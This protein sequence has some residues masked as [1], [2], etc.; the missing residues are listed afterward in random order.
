ML[1]LFSSK[2]LSILFLAGSLALGLW[3][4]TGQQSQAAGTTYHVATSGNDN[5][6]GTQSSPFRTLQKAVSAVRPGDTVIVHAGRYAGFGRRNFQGASGSPI[7]IKAAPGEHVILDGYITPK[8]GSGGYVI[9]LGGVAAHLI[10]DGFEITNSDPLIDQ[11]RQLPI[12][13][14]SDCDA[15]YPRRAKITGPYYGIRLESDPATSH[16]LVFKNLT[17]HHLMGV[18]WSGKTDFTQ[19]LNNHVYDLGYPSSGYGWY[20]HGDNIVWR[21][22][23]VHDNNYGFHLYGNNP[24]GP[25]PL[26]NS[27]I[28][29]NLIYKNGTRGKWCH[30][31]IKDGGVGLYLDPGSGNTLRNNIIFNNWTGLYIGDP[32]N[33][34]L[35]NTFY[36]NS[37]GGL[38]ADNP[39]ATNISVKN[40][41]F[42]KN[43]PYDFKGSGLVMSHNLTT[44]P[45]FVNT[46]GGNFQLQS[47]SPAINAGVTLTDVPCDFDGNGRPA[48][49][50]YDIGAY[51]YG[52]TPSS[53]CAK[54]Q[55]PFPPRP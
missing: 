37:H 3:L 52:G 33:K 44:D 41:I 20:T 55:V 1:Y 27:I 47:G 26:T 35:N 40:N 17:V 51:E 7:T 8:A 25:I 32:N 54:A 21:G 45:K 28:E 14:Q 31:K 50:A 15:W 43:S 13:T 19:Y 49:S 38:K 2:P 10:I 6:S 29:N 16:H 30:R 53:S 4:L 46:S 48:G 12:L 36:G 24:A 5:N 22:N 34:V 9:A 11:F 23:I 18:G 39:S 42:F